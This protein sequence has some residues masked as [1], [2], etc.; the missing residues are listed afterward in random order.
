MSDLLPADYAI[1]ALAA[2]LAVTGLFRGLSGMV[3]FL[4]GSLASAFA[5][6][7]GWDLSG[8]YLDAFWQRALAVVVLSV[9]AFGLVRA[10]F[11]KFIHVLVSQPGD[12]I[13]GFLSGAAVGVSLFAFWAAIG[14]GL[15]QSYVASL[16]NAAF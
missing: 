3:A 9:L 5:A 13:F 15:E 7:S 8:A 4:A 16:L 2:V 6:S 10:V 11:A 12:S 14:L 1:F